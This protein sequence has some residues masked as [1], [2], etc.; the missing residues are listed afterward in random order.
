MLTQSVKKW[1]EGFGQEQ[2]TLLSECQDAGWHMLLRCSLPNWER[3][4]RSEECRKQSANLVKQEQTDA[5]RLSVGL[6]AK[7]PQNK[8]GHGFARA[9][10][11]E[12]RWRAPTSQSKQQKSRELVALAIHT[13]AHLLRLRQTYPICTLVLVFCIDWYLYMCICVNMHT[14]AYMCMYAQY[15][16]KYECM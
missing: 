8:G 3:R 13:R 5:V 4:Q 15:V 6:S 16:F 11:W 1:R 12:M 2:G 14:C 7:T 10:V 9:S